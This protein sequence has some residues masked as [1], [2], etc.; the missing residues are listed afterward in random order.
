MEEQ[1]IQQLQR[2]V[3]EQV[4]ERA[5]ADPNWRQQLLEDPQTAMDSIPEA[6]QLQE[7]LES[8]RPTDQQPPEAPTPPPSIRAQE[9]EYRQLS[10]S[11]TD[12]MLDR[13]ASDPTWKQ[14]LL[15]D[16][17]KAMAEANFPELTRLAEIR[18]REEEA[19]PQVRG[20]ALDDLSSYRSWWCRG[21]WQRWCC[22][23]YTLGR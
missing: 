20:H 16:P 9:E 4:L 7:I 12:K 17:D 8:A 22:L 23:R 15:E 3:D 5:E 18:Q 21:T 13:A 10:R 14:Q 11:L 6:R 19:G 1:R 2:R